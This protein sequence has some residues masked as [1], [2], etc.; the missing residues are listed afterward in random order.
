MKDSEI[1]R[2]KEMLEIEQRTSKAKT[3]EISALT[4]KA[5]VSQNNK[6]NELTTQIEEL[7]A[8]KQRLIRKIDQ[9]N[10]SQ[11]VLKSEVTE[12]DKIILN[13]L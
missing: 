13:Y 6:Y 10:D 5:N 2:L 7:K 12:K 3:E 11:R 4:I 9:L 8:E 1:N